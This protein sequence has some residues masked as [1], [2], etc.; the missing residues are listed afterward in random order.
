MS[1][2]HRPQDPGLLEDGPPPDAP[3]PVHDGEKRPRVVGGGARGHRPIVVRVLDASVP[4]D[5]GESGLRAR[6]DR[7][8]TE[9]RRDPVVPLEVRLEP[10]EPPV[11][12]DREVADDMWTLHGDDLGRG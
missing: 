10:V 6:E 8:G 1:A 3:A 4:L 5:R 2:T 9:P 7:V 11:Q 12:A